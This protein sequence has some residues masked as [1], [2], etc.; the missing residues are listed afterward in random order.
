[1]TQITNA[2]MSANDGLI[3]TMNRIALIIQ[4]SGSRL[5][6]G[7]KNSVIIPIEVSV[8]ALNLYRQL[9]MYT[10]KG[11]AYK[12][13]SKELITKIKCQY[14]SQNKPSILD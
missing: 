5:L 13:H 10:Y 9:I 6:F 3:N 14:V 12:L 7:N 4:F 8:M 2:Y 1:M 11:F